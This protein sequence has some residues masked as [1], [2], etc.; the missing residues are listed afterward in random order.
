M[1]GQAL[2]TTA[3]VAHRAALVDQEQGTQV[4][5]VFE[6]ANVETVCFSVQF[7]VN[8]SRRVTA[9][10]ASVFFELN[11]RSAM[12]GLMSTS[13]HAIDNAAGKQ[14]QV[15]QFGVVDVC[16]HLDS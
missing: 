3:G 2:R 10:I 12:F 6:L 8:G 13:R 5:F 7:P 11:A 1:F 4:G 14:L 16:C 9:G 15:F